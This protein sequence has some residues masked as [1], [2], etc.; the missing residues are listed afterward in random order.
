M[1]RTQ[2]SFS[3]QSKDCGKS[4]PKGVAG[5]Y[6]PRGHVAFDV[7]LIVWAKRRQPQA[8]SP[9]EELDL[10]GR[11]LEYVVRKFFLVTHDV[12]FG[13]INSVYFGVACPFLARPW[14]K[15]GS[16]EWNANISPSGRTGI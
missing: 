16:P 1:R 12:P 14:L 15:P 2:T 11:G 3:F 6:L 9:D 4:L 5:A 13:N 10:G 8:R 7:Q